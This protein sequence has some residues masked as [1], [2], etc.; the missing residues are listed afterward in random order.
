VLDE[1]GLAMH[2]HRRLHRSRSVVVG[3]SFLA[4]ALCVTASAEAEATSDCS[5]PLIDGALQDMIDYANCPSA[6]LCGIVS[7]DDA[8]DICAN[9]SF[10]PC[11]DDL[12]IPC[13]T[14][15]TQAQVYWPN[16]AD[17]VLTVAAHDLGTDVLY[18]GLR[19]ASAIGDANGDGDAGSDPSNCDGTNIVEQPGIGTSEVYYLWL[20]TDCDGV[21]DIAIEVSNETVTVSPPAGAAS[22]AY[23]DTDLELSIAGLGLP[24]VFCVGAYVSFNFD[25][26]NDDLS[27]A[28]CC[29]NPLPDIS[30]ELMCPAGIV[31][32]TTRSITATVSNTGE[33]ALSNVS[34]SIPLPAGLIFDS[35][36]NEAGWDSCDVATNTITCVEETLPLADA[37]V[38]TF[39]VR[40]ASDCSNETVTA[41]AL[42][43]FSQPDCVVE[44]AAVSQTSCVIP[45]SETAVG[46]GQKIERLVRPA[47]NP[48][49]ASTQM[50]YAVPLG[51]PAKVRIAIYDAAGRQ[52]RSLVIGEQ[53]PGFYEVEWDG[54]AED[55]SPTPAGVY[56]FR[57]S[58][59]ASGSV[60][61]IVLVR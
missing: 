23:D 35:F 29:G 59:G 21:P 45:C 53:P 10:N 36:T 28:M 24:L 4:L 18:L 54:R 25:G 22:F 42:G 50:Q 9:S 2:M 15:S 12:I 19:T 40:A 37:R 39:D 48:F 5:A 26:F 44:S 16:G 60:S 6:S 14:P 55:G 17:I 52:V 33:T 43:V 13:T 11:R 31:P 32:N 58:V 49:S 34:L 46:P 56:F 51:D 57:M 30:A 20:D 1:R 47:P 7:S 41:E 3:T 38:L 61:R 27:R 8:Q